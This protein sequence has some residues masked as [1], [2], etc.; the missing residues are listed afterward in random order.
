MANSSSLALR[1]LPPFSA[2][3]SRRERQFFGGM[4]F[5]MA[6]TA[7]IGFA[8]SYYVKAYFDAPPALTPL[9]HWHGIAFTA[10]MALLVTQTSLIKAGRADLHRRFGVAGA[11]LVPVMMI[12]AALVMITRLRHGV[13]G[14]PDGPP[15]EVFL[16]I[17]FA[18][19]IV[20][21]ALVGAALYFRHRADYHKR[22]MLLATIELISA[23]IG[24][25]P[26]V[27]D[28]GPPLFFAVSDLFVVALVLYDVMTRKHLHP[29]TLW[30]GVFLVLSQPLRLIVTRTSA[31]HEFATWLATG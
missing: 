16:A 19:L 5:A 30:G 23:A 6:L 9:L 4:A 21:P 13:L 14:P 20:F 1:D 3:E 25:M 27:K 31:W 28:G 17:P 24:R 29:A 22:L 11:L 18:T 12:L 2:S 10:W 8:P 7:F 15:P 26:G